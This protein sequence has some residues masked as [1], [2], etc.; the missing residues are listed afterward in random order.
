MTSSFGDRVVVVQ[1]DIIN[2]YSKSISFHLN[3][4][5]ATRTYPTYH[6]VLLCIFLYITVS[7]NFNSITGSFTVT[8]LSF[9]HALFNQKCPSSSLDCPDNIEQNM[10]T[11]RPRPPVNTPTPTR[12][13]PR[14]QP[15]PQ[16]PPTR[17]PEPPKEN[18][19]K[20]IIWS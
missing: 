10:Q 14:P 7:H 15:Q 1:I 3:I 18:P 17:K 16:P 13:P 6:I 4:F 19:S 5:C 2:M 9:Q 12:E 11:V 20:F 8:T